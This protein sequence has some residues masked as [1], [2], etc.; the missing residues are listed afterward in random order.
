[1]PRS[2]SGTP[3]GPRSRPRSPGGRRRD[4]K[5]RSVRVALAGDQGASRPSPRIGLGRFAE[6]CVSPPRRLGEAEPSV[7][8]LPQPVAPLREDPQRAQARFVLVAQ[9]QMVGRLRLGIELH[10]ARVVVATVPPAG[11]GEALGAFR[12]GATLEARLG[13]RLLKLVLL[14]TRRGRGLGRALPASVVQ[15]A[16]GASPAPPRLVPRQRAL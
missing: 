6:S 7:L 11:A 5:P 15:A 2:N 4:G 1:M 9:R 10:A 14:D 13:C 16:L 12:F 3:S 8:A